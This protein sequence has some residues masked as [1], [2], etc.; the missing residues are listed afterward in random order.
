MSENCGDIDLYLNSVNF[1]LKLHAQYVY[2]QA[3]GMSVGRVLNFKAMTPVS[4]LKR[5]NK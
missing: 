4:N 2:L 1:I 5:D 3:L